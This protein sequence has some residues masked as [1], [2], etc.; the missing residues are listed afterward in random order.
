[1]KSIRRGGRPKGKEPVQVYLD[2]PDRELLEKL[3][4]R[5]GLPRAELLRRGLRR[6]AESELAERGP[7]WSLERLVGA[8]GM[9]PALPSDLAARHDDYLYG[10]NRTQPSAD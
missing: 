1:M 2:G 9:D 6:L 10:P 7:G 5:T 4:R 3:A 8:L